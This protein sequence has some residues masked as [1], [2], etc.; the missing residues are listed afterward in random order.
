MQDR[1]FMLNDWK[2]VKNGAALEL[3][4]KKEFGAQMSFLR[5]I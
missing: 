3:E 1:L 5:N 2:V 4:A